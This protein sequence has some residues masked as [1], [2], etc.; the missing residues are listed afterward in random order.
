MLIMDDFQIVMRS[1]TFPETVANLWVPSNEHSMPLG[2]VTTW[3]MI[4]AA[5]RPSNLPFV[6]SLQGPLAVVAGMVLVYLFVR[7]EM[8]HP[9]PALLAMTLFGVTTHYHDAVFWF[10][11]S[12]G[13]LAL[14][15]L[16][17]GLLAAQSWLRTG[18]VVHL[19]LCALC[20]ALAPG[21]FA[22]G[23]LAGPLCALYLGG[24]AV[25][26]GPRR[27]WLGALAPLAGLALSL[28]ITL[29]RNA[30]RIANLQRVE[31]DA[32]ALQT[33]NPLTGALYTCRSLVDDVVPGMLGIANHPRSETSLTTPPLAVP[34]GLLVLSIA[35]VWWWL[36]APARPLLLL[37]LGCILTSYFVVY[38][39]RA[40]LEYDVIHTWGR[41][42]LYAHLGTSLYVAGGW[43]LRRLVAGGAWPLGAWAGHAVA[44]VALALLVLAQLP[45]ASGLP[46][47][48]QQG[49]DF[50]RIEAVD[51]V[52]R[53]HRIDRDTARQAL[54]PFDVAGC[55]ERELD[56]RVMSGW[57]F[58]RGSP[59]PRP[60]SVEEAR[61]VLAPVAEP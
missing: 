36:R 32:T 12:F 55:F 50:R 53:E 29:P 43:P 59:D 6:C 1:W 48:P 15:T 16:L 37:G 27:R 60:I 46:Y 58:L 31:S 24:S 26:D 38:S 39:G 61:E 18:R 35:A 19:F 54:T 41:Y 40:Y 8:G 23:V 7:R 14:D 3:L 47:N 13:L 21:W 42:H 57:D 52:C 11:A 20:S 34:L 44:A 49:K 9:F 33:T 51:A 4:W 30:D 56:G 10:S 28:A 45:R 17:L 25:L 2:R 22:T 5:G